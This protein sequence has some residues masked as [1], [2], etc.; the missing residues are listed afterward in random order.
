MCGQESSSHPLSTRACG[1]MGCLFPKA[2][3][4]LQYNSQK[5]ECSRYLKPS[6]PHPALLHINNNLGV[7]G[8]NAH[9]CYRNRSQLRNTLSLGGRR[10]Q[11]ENILTQSPQIPSRF[12]LLMGPGCLRKK[13]KWKNEA[14]SV[15]SA[16]SADEYCLSLR[17]T[18]SSSG[19]SMQQEII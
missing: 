2:L 12:P 17:D 8:K 1:P 16:W 13:R 19:R 10:K 15:G 11:T 5:W 6:E 14:D 4:N 9:H 7:R 18:G 3:V